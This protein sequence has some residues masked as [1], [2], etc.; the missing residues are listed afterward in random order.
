MYNAE[1]EELFDQLVPEIG[2]AETVAGEIVRAI[3]QIGYR[4]YN[5]GDHLGVGY[6]RETCNP[7]GRYLAKKCNDM[8]ALLIDKYGAWK[9]TITTI[10]VLRYLKTL[11]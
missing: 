11:F 6:G 2:S 4:C 8:I 10:Q 5:D 9:T 3:C 7:A 1:L